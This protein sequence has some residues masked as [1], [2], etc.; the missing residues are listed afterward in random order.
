[1]KKRTNY[2]ED[3]EFEDEVQTYYF[4][5]QAQNRKLQYDCESACSSVIV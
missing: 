4:Y 3:T 2:C 5:H 1:M